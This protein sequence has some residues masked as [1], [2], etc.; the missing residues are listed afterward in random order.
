MHYQLLMKKIYKTLSVDN[1]ASILNCSVQ[2][3]RSL[4]RHGRLPAEQI[5]KTWVINSSVLEEKNLMFELK[6]D[7]PQVE[8]NIFKAAENVTLDMILGYKDKGIQHS[9]LDDY[10]N[11]K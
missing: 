2:Y 11:K 8:Q 9:F 3:V 5:G 1:M 4:I 6:K 10:E 7:I